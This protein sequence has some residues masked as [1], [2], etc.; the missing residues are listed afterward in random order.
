MHSTTNGTEGWIMPSEHKFA[1][2]RAIQTCIWALPSQHL[3][4]YVSF[5]Q[6]P[7][8]PEDHPSFFIIFIYTI[9]VVGRIIDIIRIELSVQVVVNII[10]HVTI[11]VILTLGLGVIVPN[12]I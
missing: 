5:R 7:Q 11:E 10:P 8:T 9:N 2:A 12:R 4:I 6:S 1:G 3:D